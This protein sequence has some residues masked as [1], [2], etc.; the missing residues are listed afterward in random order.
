MP[1]LVAPVSSDRFLRLASQ[2]IQGRASCGA[3]AIVLVCMADLFLTLFAVLSG[4]A[5]ESNPLLAWTFDYGPLCFALVKTASFVPGVLALE[6]S[7]IENPS[8]AAW[9]ARFGVYGY[10]A[11]Y[12]FGSL[13]IHHLI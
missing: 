5:V 1:A 13:R 3:L 12:L 8:F 9:A 10:M 2:A 7:R 11:V 4:R 6:M